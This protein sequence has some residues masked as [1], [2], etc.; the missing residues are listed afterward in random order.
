MTA[1]LLLLGVAQAQGFRMPAGDS[2]YSSF[3]ITAYYDHG[4]STDW[5]CGGI[6]Y[7]GH[8]GSDFG[9]GSWAGMDAGMDIVAAAD[10]VVGSI[11]DGEFDECTTADC[12]GGGGYGNHVR[13]DHSDGR[14]TI[15]AHMEK[16]SV[17]VSEG[18]VV[19]CGTKLGQVGSSGYSTGPHL[20][21]ELRTSGN[22][23]VDPFSGSCSTSSSSSWVSQ[24]SYD[25]LPAPSCDEPVGACE[26]V[27]TLTCGD[28]VTGRNDGSGATTDHWFYGCGEFTYSGS[29]I[30]YEILTDRSEPVTVSVS[31]LS[32]DLDLFLLS[33]DACDGSGCL[34]G[35]TESET[36]D[37]SVTGDATAEVPL[38]AVI[39]GWE[40][41]RSDFTLSVSCDGKLPGE[42][43][44]TPD[45]EDTATDTT[46]SD[47][48]PPTDTA[49]DSRPPDP[50]PDGWDRVERPGGGGLGCSAVPSSSWLWLGGLLAVGRRRYSEHSPD[51]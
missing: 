49:P 12:S 37:E 14:E 33:G 46:L 31:G 11:H 47:S 18:Q 13:V 48:D 7:S 4:G 19:G 1:W 8:S 42:D 41:A 25:S 16:W 26:P 40:D 20:H 32:Q 35:S 51:V 17:A 27:Q 9:V 45:T 3:Y 6:S 23:R 28:S 24:G 10:G 5:N 2:D 38:V 43:T 36:S 22:D 15:Y 34:A 50:T 44:D 29:E 39:D 21:F 30:A